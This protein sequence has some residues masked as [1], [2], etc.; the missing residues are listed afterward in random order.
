[1]AALD[2]RGDVSG[3]CRALHAAA[4]KRWLERMRYDG[5]FSVMIS[6]VHS[7]AVCPAQALL[8]A[9]LRPACELSVV[10]PVRDEEASLP[11]TLAAL[12]RQR[13]TDGSP[14]AP[15]RYEIIL[16]INNATDGSA[17]VAR[18]FA[19]THP[20]LALH[21]VEV[22]L[23]VDEAHVGRAR[24]MLMDAAAARLLSLGRERGVIAT[25]D[26]DTIVAPDWIAMTLAEVADGADAVAGRILVDPAGFDLHERHARAFHLRD[27][28][29]RYLVTELEARLDPDPSDPWPRHF[30]HFGASIAVTVDAYRR[31]GGI[32]PLP[33]LEDVALY[34]AL[35]RIGARIRHSPAVRVVT[36]ARPVGRTGF[37]FAV[38]LQQWSGMGERHEPFLVE[39]LPA[40]LARISERQGLRDADRPATC[41]PLVPIDMAISDLRRYLAEWRSGSARSIHALE[42]VQPVRFLT[43]A[44]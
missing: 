24:R 5:V 13:D 17:V 27:V 3:T 23:P 7:G 14:L 36:S 18:A 38:Q 6:I 9:P 39:S 4:A 32:P 21:V 37:G 34:D 30:Q 11:G 20:E 8:R 19:M 41:Q 26:A 42:Q 12:A 1:A 44:D 22:E 16:L 2:D 28:T 43:A 25:T 31:S 33:F 10:I 40:I 29:Y 15:D 35:R